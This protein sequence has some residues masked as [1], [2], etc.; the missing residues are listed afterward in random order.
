M[1]KKN[2]KYFI[3]T[4]LF[5]FSVVPYHLVQAESQLSTEQKLGDFNTFINEISS[6]YAAFEY[7][8]NTNVVRWQELLKEYR[9]KIHQSQSNDAFYYLLKEF[10]ARFRD[11]HNGLRIRKN[12]YTLFIPGLSFDLIQDKVFLSQRPRLP[13]HLVQDGLK[14]ADVFRVEEEGITA[15]YLKRG[16]ELI[17]VNNIPIQVYL[18]NHLL[19]Y[20]SFSSELAAKKKATWHLTLRPSNKLP[21]PKPLEVSTFSF[22]TS[23]GRRVN[24]EAKWF[25]VGVPHPFLTEQ[26]AHYQAYQESSLQIPSKG[27]NYQSDWDF[28]GHQ[29]E[30]IYLCTGYS[31]FDV[32]KN[33]QV[34][35]GKMLINRMLKKNLEGIPLMRDIIAENDFVAYY[36]NTEVL[37]DGKKKLKTIGYLR[38]PHYSIFRGRNPVFF[39][40][41][42]YVTVDFYEKVIDEM[43]KKTDVLV[44]DQTNNCGGNLDLLYRV[45]SMFISQDFQ[46]IPTQYIANWKFYNFFE[47]NPN[48]PNSWGTQ[49]HN[50]SMEIA[51]SLELGKHLTKP[52]YDYDSLQ[53]PNSVQYT[54]PILLLVNSLALSAADIFPD[55]LKAHNPKVVI[56]GET[57]GGGGGGS[58][59]PYGEELPHSDI[60]YMLMMFMFGK[61]DGQPMENHGVKPHTM[62]EVTKEDFLNHRSNY[63]KRYEAL[64]G[65]MLS[66]E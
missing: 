22:Q 48:Y 49:D 51:L 1:K 63:R 13:S 35:Q 53:K 24:L 5:I 6:N 56:M 52:L 41:N 23:S 37:I 58:L 21:S 42:M 10:L 64:I 2:K 47:A 55:I 61:A 7:K 16:L 39:P 60:N 36:Y 57:T 18:K 34:L 33:H 54:K 46:S 8:Q 45:T 3:I 4:F 15:T 66:Q 20:L 50:I 28:A 59:F 29:N 30:L 31:S 26:F 40:P 12:N 43:N 25:P 62:Y 11:S 14:W 32:P 27:I 38:I 19:K 17:A 65:R 44:I 9:E